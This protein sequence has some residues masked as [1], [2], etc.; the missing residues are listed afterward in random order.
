MYG[1]PVR[2]ASS[3][4][5]PQ[6]SLANPCMPFIFTWQEFQL[7]KYAYSLPR[8][9]NSLKA[10]L[11]STSFA[12]IVQVGTVPGACPDVVIHACRACEKPPYFV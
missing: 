6:R 2:N 11:Y 3:T 10:Q 4:R 8:P 7:S 9:L 12:P 1:I 5:V